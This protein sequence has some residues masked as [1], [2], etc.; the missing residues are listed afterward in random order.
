MKCQTEPVLAV[1]VV[2]VVVAVAGVD[3]EYPLCPI[4]SNV[5]QEDFLHCGPLI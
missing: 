3:L 5:S 4:L 1:V 2:V